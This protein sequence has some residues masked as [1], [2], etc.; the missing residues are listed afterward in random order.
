MTREEVFIDTR[1]RHA[2]KLTLKTAVS[3]EGKL[4]AIPYS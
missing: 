3:K 2:M 4:L 1:T